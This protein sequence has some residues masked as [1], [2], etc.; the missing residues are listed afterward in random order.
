MKDINSSLMDLIRRKK[1]RLPSSPDVAMKNILNFIKESPEKKL[2]LLKV[3]DSIAKALRNTKGEK[4]KTQNILDSL[5]PATVCSWDE[6]ESFLMKKLLSPQREEAE[7]IIADILYGIASESDW[8]KKVR[9]EIE[10]LTESMP[11]R[12]SIS[13]TVRLLAGRIFL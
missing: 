8:D 12:A 10:T 1:I 2:N 9:E 13:N 7:S 5:F 11:V 6:S 3:I 4:E